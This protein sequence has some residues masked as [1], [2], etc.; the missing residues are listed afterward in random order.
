MIS[1]SRQISWL[2]WSEYFCYQYSIKWYAYFRFPVWNETE[3]ESHHAKTILS[4]GLLISPTQK[5]TNIFIEILSEDSSDQITT[6]YSLLW[7]IEFL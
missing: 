2:H 1:T 5:N 4:G 7:F 6:L 3:I